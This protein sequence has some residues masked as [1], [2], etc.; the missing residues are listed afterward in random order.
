MGR[1]TIKPSSDR[2]RDDDRIWLTESVRIAVSA[3]SRNQRWNRR[4]ETRR[5]N[6]MILLDCEAG[7]HERWRLWVAWHGTCHWYGRCLTISKS[8]RSTWGR[9]PSRRA[10]EGDFRR[11]SF[12]QELLPRSCPWKR[13]SVS[14]EASAD[15]P[16]DPAI[17]R[18]N[19][20]HKRTL[21]N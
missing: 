19:P 14:R 20:V 9:V 16:A 21:P 13:S 4:V 8:W 5:A 6:P 18:S 10:A 11:F 1:G 17:R 3:H 12:C 2:L 15:Q 7:D